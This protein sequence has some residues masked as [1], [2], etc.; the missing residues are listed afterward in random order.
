[1]TPGIDELAERVGRLERLFEEGGMSDHS[2]VHS[3][4]SQIPFSAWLKISGP[5]FAVMALGF[6]V[7]W[8]AQQATTQQL[9]DLEERTTDRILALQQATTDRILAHQ[10]ETTDRILEMQQQMLDL[11]RE[12]N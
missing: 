11:H 7:V 10:R 2:D 8:N 1:M 12:R 4:W 5:T 6:G 3:F 9:I